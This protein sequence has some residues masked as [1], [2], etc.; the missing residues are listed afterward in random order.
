MSS[1]LGFLGAGQMGGALAKGAVLGKVYQPNELFFCD[2]SKEQL[3]KMAATFP[4]CKTT[5][6]AAELMSACKQIILAVKP[7][8]IPDVANTCSDLLTSDH[9]I[10]SIAAGISLDRL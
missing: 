10:I 2:P 8:V 1:K 3:E 4:G 9:A 5:S 6:D 7:Q